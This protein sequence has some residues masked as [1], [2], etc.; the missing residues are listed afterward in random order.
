V[1]QCRIRD[2]TTSDPDDPASATETDAVRQRDQQQHLGKQ[3]EHRPGVNHSRHAAAYGRAGTW[4][5]YSGASAAQRL[6]GRHYQT[7]PKLW[8]PSPLG[9]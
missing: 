4:R 5:G 6:G 2:R 8:I 3:P 7:S 1:R 9:P